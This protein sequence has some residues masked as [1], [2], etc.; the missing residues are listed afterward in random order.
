[1]REDVPVVIIREW[2]YCRVIHTAMGVLVTVTR[3]TVIRIYLI[4]N[5]ERFVVI[6]GETTGALY[7]LCEAVRGTLTF[8]RSDKRVASLCM[9]VTITP[10]K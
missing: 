2:I 6:H 1:M 9:S 3:L 10:V 4:S 7:T 8:V 5:S